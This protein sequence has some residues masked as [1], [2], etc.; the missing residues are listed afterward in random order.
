[1]TDHTL[2]TMPA[3]EFI[4]HLRHVMPRAVVLPE[5][6]MMEGHWLTPTAYAIQEAARRL[7]MWA[8]FTPPDHYDADN[9]NALNRR[10]MTWAPRLEITPAALTVAQTVDEL[11]LLATNASGPGKEAFTE[12][13]YATCNRLR[14]LSET[15]RQAEATLKVDTENIGLREKLTQMTAWRDAAV[16]TA[17]ATA[18]KLAATEMDVESAKTRISTLEEKYKKI[19]AF[20]AEL[21]NSRP[22]VNIP[23]VESEELTKLRKENSQALSLLRDRDRLIAEQKT[24]LEAERVSVRQWENRY[25]AAVKRSAELL[26]E[27]GEL[28]EASGGQEA[29][30]KSNAMLRDELRA[31]T[32]ALKCEKECNGRQAEMLRTLREQP[33]GSDLAINC[34]IAEISGALAFTLETDEYRFVGEFLLPRF[35]KLLAL[36]GGER[37]VR[38]PVAEI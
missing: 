28:R 23:A 14:N 6:T 13:L 38:S 32:E 11:G 22:I 29:L 2:R 5:G 17:N 18:K 34:A 30:D 8:P 4:H 7:G 3:P 36:L 37:K 35:E 21:S 16:T 26:V 31:A 10:L 25:R 33:K 24:V 27:N 9:E 15:A 20:N 19:A 12:L 1:M